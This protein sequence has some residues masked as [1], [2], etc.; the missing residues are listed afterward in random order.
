MAT[1]EPGDRNALRPPQLWLVLGLVLGLGLEN[2]IS[3]LFFGFGLVVGL[4]LT[5]ERR[6]LRTPWPWYGGAIA[7]ALFLPQVVWQVL[8]GWST[9]EFIRRASTIKNRPLSV[10]DFLSA[11]PSRSTP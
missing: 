8:H 2:K 7:L 4:L 11:R 3:V 5:R 10:L 1:R 6:H 9:L